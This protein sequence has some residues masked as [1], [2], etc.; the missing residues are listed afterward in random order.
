MPFC[1]KCRAEYVEGIALCSNCQVELVNEL[2]PEYE[3]KATIQQQ[4]L[5]SQDKKEQQEE[6]QT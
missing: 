3:G 1:P 4:N 5:E 6:E 2:P